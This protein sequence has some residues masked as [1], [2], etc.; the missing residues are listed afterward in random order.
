[1]TDNNTLLAIP[2]ANLITAAKTID[3]VCKFPCL[4]FRFLFL[5]WTTLNIKVLLIL[6]V[7][8]KWKRLAVDNCKTI[9]NI[10]FEQ[11]WSVG[12]GATLGDG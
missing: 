6:R 7:G 10:E 2:P 8:Q 12:L 1:M 9:Q 4:S 3:H 11:N 5:M